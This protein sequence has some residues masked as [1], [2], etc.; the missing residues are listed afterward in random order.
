MYFDI[1]KTSKSSTLISSSCND[2]MWQYRFLFCQFNLVL[3]VV[4]YIGCPDI[5]VLCLF[6]LASNSVL[7]V[8]LGPTFHCSRDICLHY[9]VELSVLCEPLKVSFLT[10]KAM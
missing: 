1:Y 4:S 6:A 9:S 7:N 10:V 3:I 8:S 2:Q 5:A